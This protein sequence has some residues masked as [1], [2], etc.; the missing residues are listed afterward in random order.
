MAD[1][2]KRRISRDW[3]RSTQIRKWNGSIYFY[4]GK[5]CA[6]VRGKMIFKVLFEFFFKM[7]QNES[8]RLSVRRLS[9]GFTSAKRIFKI[10]TTIQII[11]FRT[12][13]SQLLHKKH[14]WIAKDLFPLCDNSPKVHAKTILKLSLFPGNGGDKKRV[15]KWREGLI[16]RVQK[17]DG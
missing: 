15:G 17:T 6:S 14:D 5:C 12:L 4:F 7:Q 3:I 1:G 10:G 13:L 16:A 11:F 2:N 9:H 8:Q